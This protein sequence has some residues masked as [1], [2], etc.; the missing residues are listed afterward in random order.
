MSR[1]GAITIRMRLSVYWYGAPIITTALQAGTLIQPIYWLGYPE[2]YLFLVDN[3]KSRSREPNLKNETL[4]VLIR[5]S[6]HHHRSASKDSD[7]A[8]H[9]LHHPDNYIFLVYKKKSCS[10]ETSLHNETLCVLIQCSNHHNRSVSR[11]SVTA[12]T[13][14]RSP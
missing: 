1:Y 12:Y 14:V 7:I 11:D 8:D 9:W 10:S 4:C 3:K 6:D 2:N 13:L 5:Y